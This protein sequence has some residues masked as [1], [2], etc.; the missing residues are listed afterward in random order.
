MNFLN[1]THKRKAFAI[2][3]SLL[4]LL[5]LLMFFFGMKYVTPPIEKGIEI[6]F[7]TDEIG[8]NKNT[9]TQIEKSEA[10]PTPPME[11]VEEKTP[12]EPIEEK[13]V[14]TQQTQESVV[15]PVKT[16]SKKVVE[17]PKNTPSTEPKKVETKKEIP[18]QKPSSETTDALANIL[19][20]TK[21]ND[22]N[23]NENQNGNQGNLQGNPYSH[24]FYGTGGNTTT[25]KG[26]GLNGRNL[27]GGQKILP[28][29]NETGRV[30]VQIEVDKTG[31][32]VKITPG[33]KGTNNNAPCL[34]EAAKKTAQTYRWNADEK[35]PERQVG[36]I[37]INFLLN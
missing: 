33:V 37:V 18:Q 36:F 35:A 17:P 13:P 2:T 14:L 6:T 28:D 34:I 30:V 5:L 24:S 22:A 9:S 12:I 16:P 23:G 11:K 4:S 3:L 29:C 8:E 19:G 15:I 32:V 27:L 1:T 26:W 10:T 25:G 7:G 20:A 31:K 21:K